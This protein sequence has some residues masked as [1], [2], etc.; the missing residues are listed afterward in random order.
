MEFSSSLVFAFFLGLIPGYI[1]QKKGRGFWQ[2]YFFGVAMFIVALPCALLAEDHSGMQCP[3]CKK[4]IK[5]EATVC[6]YCHTVIADFYREQETVAEA[7]KNSEKNKVDDT[8][9]VETT[10][11][12]ETDS[13]NA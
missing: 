7:Q 12:S 2:W 11:K 6:K 13:N 8:I 1:G 4:W 10:A 9:D 5:E 3:K